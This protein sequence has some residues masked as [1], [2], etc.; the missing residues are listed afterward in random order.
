MS[1]SRSAHSSGT[2]VSVEHEPERT[3]E[4]VE[5]HRVRA[6]DVSHAPDD[7]LTDELAA[8]GAERFADLLQRL[9]A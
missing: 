7:E 3:D 6:D 4:Q 1:A 2:V 9:G 5:A 8:Q